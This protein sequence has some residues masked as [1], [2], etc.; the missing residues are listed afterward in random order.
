MVACNVVSNNNPA[1][2]L[3]EYT[4][5]VYK[6]GMYGNTFNRVSSSQE[7]IQNVVNDVSVSMSYVVKNVY[8]Q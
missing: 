7:Y 6:C 1:V 4:Q 8:A 3:P 5:D 2:G